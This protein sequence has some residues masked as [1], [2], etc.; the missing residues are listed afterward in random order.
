ML[1][2]GRCQVVHVIHVGNFYSKI[3]DDEAENDAAS[4]VTPE[5][6]SVLALVVSFFGK[7]LLEELVG[8][9]AGLGEA[10]H[11][12]PNFDVDPSNFVNQVLEVV[13]Y[14]DL[15]WDDV[16]LEAH[17]FRIGYR[18]VKVK[19]GQVNA[20]EHGTRCTYPEVDEE[21]GGEK[22][23]SGSALVSGEVDEITTNH[24]SSAIDLY[25]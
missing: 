25:L 12:F 20:K 22:V 8:N 6:R 19:V 9:D 14:D 2:Q 16:E 5:A 7:S 4:D 10:I 21:F 15:F 11:S 3:I 17:V 13:F 23:C 24:E 1:F 18:G